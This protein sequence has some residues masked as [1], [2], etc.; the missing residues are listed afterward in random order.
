M[1]ESGSVL[2][3]D[4]QVVAVLRVRVS[5]TGRL[6]YGEAIEA[7]SERPWRFSTWSGLVGQLHALITEAI[8]PTGGTADPVA[9]P[10][11]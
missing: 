11:P 1:I 2:S 9:K 7:E 6:R 5:P 3:E 8:R 10:L 4:R